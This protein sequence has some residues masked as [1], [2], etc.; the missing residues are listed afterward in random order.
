M[1]GRAKRLGE[2][3]AG[4]PVSI[5]VCLE[6]YASRGVLGCIGGNG[7]GG[8]EVWELENGLEGERL[9]KGG[10]GG[11]ARFIPFPGMRFLGEIEEGACGVGV[12]GDKASIEIG[13]SED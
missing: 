9:F 10:E 11:V 7:E 13:K 1:F 12:V 2:V 8:R 5:D 3:G 4:V 6:E